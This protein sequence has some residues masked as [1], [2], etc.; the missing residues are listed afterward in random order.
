[1][2]VK[3]IAVLVMMIVITGCSTQPDY[4]VMDDT[5]A[6]IN[7]WQSD[8]ALAD[9]QVPSSAYDAL[10]PQID[11][12]KVLEQR[13]D[14]VSKNNS[15]KAFF[16]GL[17]D[18]MDINILVH[19]KVKQR[20]SL[21]LKNVTL[22]E[23]LQAVRDLYGLQYVRTQYGYQILPREIQNKV[24]H[25]NYLNVS[26]QGSSGM[27]VS[28]GHISD[29]G[30]TSSSSSDGSTSSSSSNNTIS[31]ASKIETQANTDFWQSLQSSV[32][33]M[34]GNGKGRRVI[35]DAQA[36]LVMVRAFPDELAAVDNYL[37]KAELSLQK[38]VIIEAKIL[39]VTL[40]DGFQAGIQ[41]D[42]FSNG[43]GTDFFTSGQEFGGAVSAATVRN[44]ESL[45]GVFSLNFNTSDFFGVIQLLKH[46]GEVQ[47]LSSPRISTVN[48]QKAVIKVGTDEFFVTDVSS[49]TTTT[50][51]TTNTAPEVSL[52]PFFSGIAL[53]VTPQIGENDDVILHVHPSVTEVVERNKVIEVGGST[54]DL[55][56][57]FSSIRETDSIIRARSGQVVVIGGLLQTK[58]SRSDAGVPWLS[59]IPILGYL[60]RQTER[61]NSK[62]EL[63]ILLQPKVI[64]T[65]SWK[66]EV[67][68]I[69]GTFPS[70]RK[71]DETKDES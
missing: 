44:S 25:V 12:T 66:S 70:W 8:K 65:S 48:N 37:K 55:P 57:A 62:S 11:H 16:L 46:Q 64:D 53:D 24:F 36:G 41:W 38:Q 49:N 27:S 9:G 43:A 29:N 54:L 52:T 28:S 34:I 47:V 5:L 56:L 7:D 22:E 21:S 31:T 14:V 20:I 18:G 2:D 35:V 3:R 33:M 68:S 59:R 15:S 45:D 51:T 32:Q 4:S 6:N 61:Q 69:K 60:F 67:D 63:V 30:T 19:P 50:T 42:S 10:T 26:R 71:K 13:F 40:N 39:E 58:K 23:T 1:M 17:V